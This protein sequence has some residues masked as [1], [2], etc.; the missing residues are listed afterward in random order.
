M[1]S[2][3]EDKTQ[4]NRP[5]SVPIRYYCGHFTDFRKIIRELI[6]EIEENRGNVSDKNT[7]R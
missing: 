6:A 1:E 5:G 4:G 3:T 7:G 2:A